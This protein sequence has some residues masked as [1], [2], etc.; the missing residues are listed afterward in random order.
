MDG[1]TVDNINI[2][3][4]ITQCNDMG[5]ADKD[6]IIDTLICG[7]PSI[8]QWDKSGNT[9]SNM[10]RSHKIGS[11]NNGANGYTDQ[12]HAH[13]DVE[14]R[15]VI[16]QLH[17]SGGLEE[18]NFNN[19]TTWALQLDGRAQAKAL[20]ECGSDCMGPQGMANLADWTQ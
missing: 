1:G 18:V 10:L 20:L 5:F 11:F 17:G 2:L 3:S 12:M 13:P 19:A 4:A 15:Y 9:I 16:N 6:I 14:W 7:N 8:S